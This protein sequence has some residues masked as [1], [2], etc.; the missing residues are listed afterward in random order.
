MTAAR[1]TSHRSAASAKP[2][3]RWLLFAHQLPAHP[4]NARVKTWR[5]L[6]QIGAV[7][8]K[9]S[10]YVLPNTAQ[11]SEDFEWLR[12]EVAGLG[13]QATVFEASSINGVEDQQIVELFRAARA[14]DYGR[15]T[16]ELRA[17]RVKL[18]RAPQSDEEAS[19]SVSTLHERVRQLQA[20]DFFS[21]PGKAEVDSA[22]AK[23]D[24]DGPRS[25]QPP[26]G[27]RKARRTVRDFQKRQWVTRPRPGVD[28]FASAWLIRRFIDPRARFVFGA[29]PDKCPDAIPF[30]MYQPGGFRHEG[31]RCTFE[32]LVDRFGIKDLALQ[33]I[34]EVVHDLDLKDER[35]KSMHAPTIGLLVEGLQAAISDDARLLEQGI[36][37]FEA[38]YLSV[39]T[40]TAPPGG[41]PKIS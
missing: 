31:D 19:R 17:V 22:L 5:R 6:Q 33:R 20:I 30:D 11:A 23:L 39:R 29:S 27:Y 32:V 4:S 13:G 26:T 14:Q 34:A 25:A 9:N 38:L 7:S 10:V 12:T 28:R 16:K 41:K 24:S 21:A 36:A 8:V 15:L 40:G 2:R 1:V 35:F 37:L 3:H 18:G